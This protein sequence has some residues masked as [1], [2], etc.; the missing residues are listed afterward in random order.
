MQEFRNPNIVDFQ[1]GSNV[2]SPSLIF[3]FVPFTLD[4]IISKP[5][6]ISFSTKLQI[7]YDIT[8]ACEFLI[9]N[10]LY[11]ISLDSNTILVSFIFLCFI[12]AN[13]LIFKIIHFF[14]FK[15]NN[16]NKKG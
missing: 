9:Q 15:I 11:N 14:F 16:T 7:L 4:S 3:S 6:K 12:N 1:G 5:E 2:S 8:A 13:F 10:R